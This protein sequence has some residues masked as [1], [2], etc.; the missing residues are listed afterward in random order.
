MAMDDYRLDTAGHSTV[1]HNLGISSYEYYVERIESTEF[2]VRNA[3]NYDLNRDAGTSLIFTHILS[4]DE[5]REAFLRRY[6]DTLSGPLSGPAMTDILN[7]HSKAIRPEME[8]HIQR[9]G[10]PSSTQLW[11]SYIDELEK[12]LR[13]RSEFMSELIQ[14]KYLK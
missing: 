7:L 8:R 3:I 9:W 6:Q 2:T 4:N 11:E 1:D 5:T 13:L 10:Y 12:F 14:K